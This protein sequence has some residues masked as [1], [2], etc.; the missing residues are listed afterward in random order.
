MNNVLTSYLRQNTEIFAYKCTTVASYFG[1]E[2]FVFEL[3][4]RNCAL[5]YRRWLCW[6]MMRKVKPS[7]R[8]VERTLKFQSRTKT[9]AKQKSEMLAPCTKSQR[10]KG[11]REVS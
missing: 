10:L 11:T 9:G 3:A 8:T 4:H 5:L 7:E 1:D 6:V 2:C